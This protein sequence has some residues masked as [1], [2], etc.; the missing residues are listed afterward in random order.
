M[1]SQ[2]EASFAQTPGGPAMF[3]AVLAAVRTSL[4]HGLEQIFLWS[5]LMM[6][7]A[8]PIHMALRSEPLRTR[9]AEADAPMH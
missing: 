5:A 7:A 4:A 3:D 9:M 2:I 6:S 8:V 1:R